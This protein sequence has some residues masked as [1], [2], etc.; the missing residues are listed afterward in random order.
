MTQGKGPFGAAAIAALG[1]ISLPPMQQGAAL[2]AAGSAALW[3][4]PAM[5]QTGIPGVGIVVKRKPGNAPIVVASDA[6]GEVRLTGLA[7]GTYTVQ[8]FDGAQEVAMTVGP[9]GRLAFV[10]LLD[11]KNPDSRPADPRL[12]GRPNPPGLPVV[13]RWAEQ[14]AFDEALTA[15]SGVYDLREIL[16]IRPYPCAAPSPGRQGACGVARNFI[17][18]NASSPEEMVR[19]SPGLSMQSAVHI[20]VQREKGGSYA[21][22]EDFA[23]RNCPANV[24]DIGQGALKIG[25]ALF[26]L[27][28]TA[29]KSA[30]PG[31]SCRPGGDGQFG[32]YGKKHNYV[33]HVTLLR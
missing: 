10:A 15:G 30:V 14:I 7:P 12:G 9:D 24:I 8:V 25:E 21:S 18:I 31:F 2:M 3:S 19:L 6:R 4:T 23:R 22:I 16:R 5:A 32:L 17:D 1:L 28:P 26:I 33:G 11:F 13:R 27:T 20:M 29:G